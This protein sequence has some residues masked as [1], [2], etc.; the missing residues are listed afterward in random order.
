MHVACTEYNIRCRNYLNNFKGDDEAIPV[1][2]M[3][4]FMYDACYAFQNDNRKNLLNLSLQRLDHGRGTISDKV[5]ARTFSEY[6]IHFSS[7]IILLNLLL[8]NFQK[9]YQLYGFFSNSEKFST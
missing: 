8:T 3:L 5:F 2:V 7:L 9:L 1:T 4:V 6:K